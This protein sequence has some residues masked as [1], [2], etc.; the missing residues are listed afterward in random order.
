MTDVFQLQDCATQE[1]STVDGWETCQALCKK[2]NALCGYI[3]FEVVRATLAGIAR[4]GESAQKI[5]YTLDRRPRMLRGHNEYDL[6]NFRRYDEE[7]DYD[8]SFEPS[9]NH[10]PIHDAEIIEKVST[11]DRVK[12]YLLLIKKKAKANKKRNLARKKAKKKN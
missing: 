3:K 1:V 5:I 9:S 11:R 6:E 7:I 4:Q 8:Q 2:A 12:D 10:A